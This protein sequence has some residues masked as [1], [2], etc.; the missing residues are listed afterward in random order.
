MRMKQ[1]RPSLA[2][3]FS[4]LCATLP[5]TLVYS[6]MPVESTSYTSSSVYQIGKASFYGGYF[7]GRKTANGEIFNENKLTAAHRT[8]PFGT[9]LK[10]TRLDNHQ[11]V[12]VTVNDRGPYVGNRVLDL[13]K[14]AAREIGM[15]DK[16]VTEVI[17]ETVSMGKP[18]MYP[19]TEPFA[20]VKPA[21]PA[22]KTKK[23]EVKD[24][25][26]KGLIPE[27]Y[28]DYSSDN[29]TAKA[30]NKEVPELIIADG[31]ILEGSDRTG[32]FKQYSQNA[33]T[34]SYNSE[35]TVQFA[36]N[37]TNT[38]SEVFASDA[39]VEVFEKPAEA[40][41]TTEV[42]SDGISATSNYV[43]PISYRG[44]AKE[45][46][47]VLPY[48]SDFEGKATASGEMYYGW[49][50]T[51]GHSSYPFGTM[52]KIKRKSNGYSVIVKVNDRVG[53]A[54]Q[55]IFYLSKAAAESLELANGGGADVEV[56]PITLE[57]IASMTVSS[58]AG[59][60]VTQSDTYTNSTYQHP[61]VAQNVEMAVP[62]QIAQAH[63]DYVAME[64]FNENTVA[65]F[66]SEN[67]D[68]EGFGL[69]IASFTDVKNALQTL[70]QIANR[71]YEKLLVQS[72]IA[73][74]EINFHVFAG[75]FSSKDE[76]MYYKSQ[77]A[78]AKIT[79]NVVFLE[80]VR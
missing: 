72:D 75:P 18:S 4:L 36:L 3:L 61:E 13:S 73:N 35:N 59:T 68:N 74:N 51:V 12:L 33:E 8:L 63:D 43:N 50:Y 62:V 80:P 14:S 53:T 27:E 15:V 79:S 34:P 71:G 37:T 25:P 11:S 44:G 54:S 17:I 9:V 39:V 24:D 48:T 56:I 7:N 29:R 64:D 45:E 65:H 2:K 21:K 66:S 23:R 46:G 52:L 49:D 6:Q 38:E 20:M 78:G 28:A 31:I 16:G 42:E 58:T 77:L 47:V 30:N 10:V 22:H 5:T 55:P 67:I 41:E 1:L 76:A 69:K 60:E 57:E 40:Q 32:A 19:N 70:E 26:R